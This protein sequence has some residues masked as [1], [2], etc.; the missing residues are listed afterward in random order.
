MNQPF[1]SKK[2][3]WISIF[4]GLDTASV[5]DALDSLGIH[6]QVLGITP[7]LSHHSETIVGSAFTVKYV[8]VGIPAGTVGDYIDEVKIGDIIV[9]DNNGCLN[10][11]VWGDILT[12]Y[13]KIKHIAGTVIDGACRDVKKAIV[14]HYPLFSAGRFMRTGKDRVEV[15]S[16][17]ST[18]S[19]GGVRVSQND[20]V[21]ADANGVVIV[22]QKQALHVAQ[23]AHKI[24]KTEKAIRKK[25]REGVSIKEARKILNYHTLQR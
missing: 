6:G 4:K 9:I 17:Q 16:I 1:E 8:P 5:S 14:K 24:E 10:C 3:E 2:Q 19:I 20:I 25:I 21:M 23:I 7:L 18:I 13:A 12:E 15:E 22:P 11:T